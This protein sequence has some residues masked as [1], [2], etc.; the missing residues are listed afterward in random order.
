MLVRRDGKNCLGFSGEA[1]FVAVIE[2]ALNISN[3]EIQ[4]LRDAV[5]DYYNR[6]LD[7]KAFGQMFGKTNSTRILV[8]AEEKSV[9]LMFPEK[10]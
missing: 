5:W 2:K 8:N 1:D 9:P 7:P 3:L 6:F 4:K 10:E